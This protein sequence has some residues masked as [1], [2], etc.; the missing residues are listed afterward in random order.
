MLRIMNL[1]TDLLGPV[2]FDL[3]KGTCTALMGASGAGKTLLL[4]A[5]VDLDPNTGEV[6]VDHQARST[7]S[8]QA[9]RESVAY[10]PAESGWWS[11]H[12]E[13]H[14]PAD[15]ET[16]KLLAAVGMTGSLAWEVARLSTGERQ[17]LAI[18]RALIRH[19]KVLLLDEPTA[20]LDEDATRRVE[21]LIQSC[22]RSNLTVLVVTHDHRQAHRLA[23]QTLVMANGKICD[24]API[25][26]DRP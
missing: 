19:P 25:A 2:S 12:V 14:F 1:K 17:R 10:V 26:R 20:S 13:D 8:A 24:P 11:D 3:P 9:W 6:F 18:A 5:I 21:A 23:R 15:V 22:C 4:R 7:M 16:E